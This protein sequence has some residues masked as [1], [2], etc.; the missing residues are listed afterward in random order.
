MYRR[1]LVDYINQDFKTVLNYSHSVGSSGSFRLPKRT[2]IDA[3]YSFM[4]NP[5]I[6]EGF[7]RSSH[8]VSLAL[9]LLTHQKD[10]GQLKLSVYDLLN[11][12]ISV[13]RYGY[14]N[15]LITNEQLILKRNVKLSISIQYP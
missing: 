15:A 13:N 14:L 5:Q 3:E 2:V 12:N 8:I 1:S 7:S 4:Y 6:T 10:L 9:S 11:Q